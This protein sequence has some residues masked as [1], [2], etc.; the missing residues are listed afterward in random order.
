MLHIVGNII[1]MHSQIT[2]T[3][4]LTRIPLH[5]DKDTPKYKLHTFTYALYQGYYNTIIRT[6]TLHQGYTLHYIHSHRHASLQGY[7]LLY[8]DSHI[9]Y[10]KDTPYYTLTL[11]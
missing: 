10:A 2:H 8:I 4:I 9:H 6:H 1:C 5:N 3:Y 11:C 7:S